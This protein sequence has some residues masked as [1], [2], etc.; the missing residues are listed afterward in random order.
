MRHRTFPHELIPLAH[1]HSA[2]LPLGRVFTGVQ[3]STF[4]CHSQACYLKNNVKIRIDLED[5]NR[6]RTPSRCFETKRGQTS[7]E[8]FRSRRHHLA[9][10]EI[11]RNPTASSESAS[12][13]MWAIHKRA[14]TGT[15]EAGGLTV[16]GEQKGEN[17]RYHY[18][19]NFI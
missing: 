15:I 14:G 3:R 4:T 12:V 16:E 19:A 13:L 1:A 8:K 17:L 6:D 18:R 2:S 11:Q 10:S 9:P 5:L 7:T